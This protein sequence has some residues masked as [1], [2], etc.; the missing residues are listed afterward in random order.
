V[1][2]HKAGIMVDANPL[3]PLASR[4]NEPAFQEAWQAEALAIATILVE[5]GV[6][7]SSSWSAALGSALKEAEFENRED[8]QETYYQCVVSA[9]E[10][11]LD[12]SGRIDRAQMVRTREDWQQAYLS[13][14]HG[15]PVVLKQRSS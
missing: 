5:Q 12:E 15:E 14:P 4:D 11:L 10:Q 3:K 7:H 6:F 2:L 13:T 9:L 8:S 1:N